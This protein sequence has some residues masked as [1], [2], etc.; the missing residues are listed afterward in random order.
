[1]SR[2]TPNRIRFRN[3][4]Y[5]L[6]YSAMLHTVQ[7]SPHNTHCPLGTKKTAHPS[8]SWNCCNESNTEGAFH[9]TARSIHYQR[10]ETEWGSPV[11]KVILLPSSETKEGRRLWTQAPR[12][13]ILQINKSH[14]WGSKLHILRWLV[15]FRLWC[16][17]PAA[18]K[19]LVNLP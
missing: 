14:A 15:K 11:T 1:M 18:T 8:V 6:K 5:N 9:C 12:N 13:S 19:D 4:V 3:T 16:G 17:R 10:N 2:C 7:C